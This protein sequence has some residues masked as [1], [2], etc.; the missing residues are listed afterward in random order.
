MNSISKQILRSPQFFPKLV[1]AA[2]LIYLGIGIPLFIGYLARYLQ[3]YKERG[4]LALPQWNH[5]LALIIESWELLVVMLAYT[6]LPMG[7]AY[8][9]SHTIGPWFGSIGWISLRVLPWI[10]TMMLFFICPLFTSIAYSRYL[11]TG[12]FESV[13]D[14]K[15]IYQDF[16]RS[17]EELITLTLLLWGALFIGFPILGFTL[18]ISSVLYFLMVFHTIDHHRHRQY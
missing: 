13:L 18:A 2:L 17:M 3:Q 16:V 6:M 15:G 8:A 9:I 14:F 4:E 12:N 7:L 5:W 11:K 10:P 1:V